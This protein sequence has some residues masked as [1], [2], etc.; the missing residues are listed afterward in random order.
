MK[1]YKVGDLI[2]SQVIVGVYYSYRQKTSFVLVSDPSG[3]VYK[4]DTEKEW[5]QPFDVQ[6]CSSL[7]DGDLVRWVLLGKEDEVIINTPLDE[8]VEKINK[9]LNDLCL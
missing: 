3:W 4:V 9:E 8:V 7:K 6:F 2:G 5:T 1:K